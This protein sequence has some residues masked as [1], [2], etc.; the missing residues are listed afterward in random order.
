MSEP[1]RITKAPTLK[2]KPKD[3]ELGFGIIF[4]DHMF[5]ANFQ[6]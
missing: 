5:V 2:K 4:T 6:E 3:S 1:I